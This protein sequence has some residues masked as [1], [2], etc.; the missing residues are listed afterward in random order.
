VNTGFLYGTNEIV[1]FVVFFALMLAATEIGFRLGRKSKA[2]T[3]ERTKSLVATVG[4]AILA[5]LG[6]LLGFTMPW[7]WHRRHTCR[8]AGGVRI[9]IEWTAA[10]LLDVGAGPGHHPD[11]CPN[12]RS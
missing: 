7:L 8:S 6:L 3:P 11:A 1:I 12:H 10:D 2:K 9:G 4:A 5:V